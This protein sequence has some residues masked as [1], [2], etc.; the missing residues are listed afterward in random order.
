MRHSLQELICFPKV[1][2]GWNNLHQDKL[3]A[4]STNAFK[5]C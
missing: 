1:G 2:G 3:D 5:P 4:P